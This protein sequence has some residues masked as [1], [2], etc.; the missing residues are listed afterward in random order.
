MKEKLLLT[1]NFLYRLFLVGF[2]F[3]VIFQLSFMSISPKLLVEANKL[4]GLP[5]FFVLEL[6]ISALVYIRVFLVYFILC[7][8]LALHWTIARDKTFKDS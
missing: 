8:A 3:S 5:P 2:L 4:L 1:R 6:V 7:P